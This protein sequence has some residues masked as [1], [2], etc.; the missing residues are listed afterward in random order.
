MPVPEAILARRCRR[1]AQCQQRRRDW[2]AFA[3][4]A[5][6]FA[7]VRGTSEHLSEALRAQ[8]YQDLLAAVLA[9]EFDHRG[10]SCVLYLDAQLYLDADRCAAG[11][12][13]LTADRLRQ[14]QEDYVGTPTVTE[15]VLAHCWAP[16]KL[17]QGWF[18]RRAIDWPLVFEPTPEVE[19]ALAD[20]DFR[21]ADWS[22][23]NVL[24]W[25]AFRDPAL[26]RQ[27]V[28]WETAPPRSKEFKFRPRPV[29]DNPE[30]AR[31][32]LDAL[33]RGH[34]TAIQNGSPVPADAWFDRDIDALS[35]KLRFKREEVLA[36][37]PERGEGRAE[38]VSRRPSELPHAPTRA[39]SAA[40]MREFV[41]CF[42]ACKRKAEGRPTQTALWEAWKAKHHR[43]PRGALFAEFTNQM[44]DD[45]PKRGRPKKSP[46]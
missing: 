41:R 17:V 30:P 16:R 2:L 3:D 1:F 36:L 20:R 15:E 28:G 40:A 23:G 4:I 21:S 9:G 31:Q 26:I 14:W 5:E 24:S 43:G 35:G 10:K 29:L 7:R 22:L 32:L 11:T 25:F 38:P 46:K 37:L 44:G 12:L 27:Y 6:W 45:A 33:K 19:A 8:A 18:K 34:L 39:A 42:I 13:R